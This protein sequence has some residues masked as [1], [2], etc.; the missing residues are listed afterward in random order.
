MNET[1]DTLHDRM[2]QKVRQTLSKPVNTE[3]EA[4][5]RLMMLRSIY[6][7][8]GNDADRQRGIYQ[9]NFTNGESK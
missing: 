4:E 1:I 3:E 2:R 5:V 9:G 7:R 8:Y 6:E